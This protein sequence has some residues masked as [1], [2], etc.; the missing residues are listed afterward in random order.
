[1]CLFYRTTII[2]HAKERLFQMEGGEKMLRGCGRT[3]EN[4]SQIGQ[5]YSGQNWQREKRI[6]TGGRR[7]NGLNIN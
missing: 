1:V 7:E 3:N 2:N 6:S 4:I 5:C